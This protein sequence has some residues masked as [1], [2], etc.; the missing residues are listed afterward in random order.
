MI[1]DLIFPNG[2][3]SLRQFSQR[4]G[5]WIWCVANFPRIS[6]TCPIQSILTCRPI[7]DPLCTG[8]WPGREGANAYA[9][10]PVERSLLGPKLFILLG[11]NS[12]RR[13]RWDRLRA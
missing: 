6:C 8:G 5:I 10:G 1:I 2:S 11:D 4:M 9:R 3:L 12:V 7:G 13:L